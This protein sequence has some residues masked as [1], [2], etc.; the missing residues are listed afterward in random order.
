[1]PTI[2]GDHGYSVTVTDRI[3]NPEITSSLLTDYNELW[4]LS[5]YPPSVAQLSQSEINAILD[6]RNQGN[7]LLIMADHTAPPDNDY[8]DDAIQIS[9]P[10]GVTFYGF[11]NQGSNG[12]PIQPDFVQH[13]LFDGVET[14]VAG[15]N[16][17][18]MTV[19]GTVEVIATYQ[20]VNL[21]AV[22][23]DGYGRVIFD[24]SFEF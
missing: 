5:T 10:L 16:E 23:D 4:F 15:S 17:G 14:I 22:L 24:V 19:D 8:S 11:T 1:M 9:V 18:D 6:F 2:L 3:T 7:G 12:Q 20:G 13:P 21:I